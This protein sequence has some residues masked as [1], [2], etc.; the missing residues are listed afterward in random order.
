MQRRAIEL[1]PENAP[2]RQFD[3]RSGRDD[4]IRLVDLWR[5]IASRWSWLAA[6]VICGSL[7]AF[8]YI[9]AT[10]PNYEAHASL[11]I[12][13]VS[14]NGL[15]EDIN[16]LSVQLLDQY[17]RE[18]GN[19]SQKRIPYLENAVEE[20]RR[21][22]ILKVIAIGRSPEEAH[23]FL[24]RIV[25]TIVTRHGEIHSSAIGP[26]EQRLA[27][28]DRRVSLLS[29][30]AQEFGTLLMRL[31]ESQPAQAALLAV[32]RA[33]VFA[34]LTELERDRVLLRRQIAELTNNQ[35]TT[36]IPVKHLDVPVAPRK[37]LASAVGVL[38]G[39]LVSLVAIFIARTFINVEAVTGRRT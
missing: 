38:L 34:E 4:E 7:A 18:L 6:G 13:K 33:R 22:N 35:T 27:G 16:A 31:K 21:S 17:G 39:F 24:S 2:A 3:R 36:I 19:G 26:L 1:F 10:P 32:E 30:Q 5:I 8:V 14:E 9:V 23:Q 12:G 11:R 29:K 25:S 37:V 15:I 28:I 20:P